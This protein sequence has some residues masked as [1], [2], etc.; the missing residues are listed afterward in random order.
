[1]KRAWILLSR[2]TLTKRISEDLQKS[3]DR[4]CLQTVY[5]CNSAAKSEIFSCVIWVAFEWYFSL[6]FVFSFCR[7]VET[8]AHIAEYNAKFNNSSLIESCRPTGHKCH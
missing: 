8:K 6:I 3:I 5:F 1:M 2:L 4:D 7:C